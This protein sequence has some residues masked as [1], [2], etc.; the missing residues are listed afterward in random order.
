MYLQKNYEALK[1]QTC[2]IIASNLIHHRLINIKDRSTD[3]RQDLLKYG[4]EKIHAAF[5]DKT[6]IDPEE[7]IK[8]LSVNNVRDNVELFK[9]T[10]PKLATFL[11]VP[12]DS[13]YC[14]DLSQLPD[15][16]HRAGVLVGALHEDMNHPDGVD[17]L[18]YEWRKSIHQDNRDERN[19]RYLLR[20]L[21]K[22]Y[23]CEHFT[24]FDSETIASIKANCETLISL[25]TD[26]NDPKAS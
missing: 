5:D 8:A 1:A 25:L 7:L 21:H 11:C 6:G 17:F 9:T 12:L 14:D 15:F 23:L 26:D 16:D 18:R 3:E 10:L 4:T 24:G 20:L 13:F 19:L 22:A 2:K